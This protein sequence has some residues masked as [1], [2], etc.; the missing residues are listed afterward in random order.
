MRVG[1]NTVRLCVLVLGLMGLRGAALACSVG[2]DPGVN[3][4]AHGTDAYGNAIVAKQ[5]IPGNCNL[6]LWVIDVYEGDTV[7]FEAAPINRGDA[8]GCSVTDNW[9]NLITTSGDGGDLTLTSV[10][11]ANPMDLFS[12]VASGIPGSDFSF[13]VNPN[14][15]GFTPSSCSP[16]AA[17]CADKLEQLALNLGGNVQGALGGGGGPPPPST[18]TAPVG[19]W[20]V[21][22]PNGA[23]TGGLSIDA[24]NVQVLWRKRVL[25]GDLPPAYAPYGQKRRLGYNPQS[26]ATIGNK[27]TPGILGG[28][29][30]QMTFSTPSFSGPDLP[31]L[32]DNR[33]A[34]FAEALLPWKFENAT[35]PLIVREVI[36]TPCADPTG[37]PP[38]NDPGC[39]DTNGDGNIDS[40]D[41][42]ISYGPN[43]P[44]TIIL[45][46]SVLKATKPGDGEGH[47]TMA[48]V[49]VRDKTPPVAA[50]TAPLE[51]L[52]TDF[53]AGRPLEAGRNEVSVKLWDNNPHA[54]PSEYEVDAWY[55]VER[56]GWAPKNG[57]YPESDF[58]GQH[59]SLPDAD[60][61]HTLGADDT[62]AASPGH[63]FRWVF[64]GTQPGTGRTELT[65]SESGET[66]PLGAEI[67]FAPF[68]IDEPTGVHFVRG[69][70]G[71]GTHH[72]YTE[73]GLKFIYK[74]REPAL[75]AAGVDPERPPG[76]VLP[77]DEPP[78]DIADDWG[79]EITANFQTGGGT[80]PPPQNMDS[81]ADPR[82]LAQ[83]PG[84]SDQLRG[85]PTWG[86]EDDLPPSVVLI[87]R[88]LKY[89]RIYYF[90]EPF[91]ADSKCSGGP[92]CVDGYNDRYRQAA[93]ADAAPPAGG[94]TE[95]M[96]I[97]P[98]PNGQPFVGNDTPSG[99]GDQ[100]S[101][102]LNLFVPT[103]STR[104]T[105]AYPG[106]WID[107][108]TRVEFSVTAWDNVNGWE[109]DGPTGGIKTSAG[110][111]VDFHL[112]DQPS[113][114]SR[115]APCTYLF[116][117]PNRPTASYGSLGDSW[118]EVRATDLAGN[119]T[120]FRVNVYI[121]DNKLRI[122]S[123]E[124]SRTRLSND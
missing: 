11:G 27:E 118:V 102:Y 122:Y 110:V 85:A 38:V 18:P 50:E 100:I 34:I 108:D 32:T 99:Y 72:V 71:D 104:D 22:G 66:V 97:V 70:N 106:L 40:G 15:G 57:S 115:D 62:W 83:V 47:P 79:G 116:R 59:A 93:F 5:A 76:G 4:K 86:V 89:E 63:V 112:E 111:T 84:N 9:A 73:K 54:D 64:L 124:E 41:N 78:L 53:K 49:S 90:G 61:S 23:P 8:T 33:Y 69:E 30:I 3:M 36:Q 43:S 1:V 67:T 16:G 14:P 117:N 92:D 26:T 95:N 60:T 28:P 103:L 7:G 114:D 88:D 82:I 123:L 65:E 29:Q 107:E 109:V 52:G 98:P 2:A 35:I 68:V 46:G 42:K 75:T 105:G 121:A 45:N 51:S 44:M 10:F 87:A 77:Q 80:I 74:I 120:E 25:E 31:G 81:D 13:S 96:T 12:F 48:L 24:A 94:Y 91:R 21:Q 37:T 113:S 119:S 101:E 20:E 56:S 6:G 17:D 39:T 19:T 58:S 55:L